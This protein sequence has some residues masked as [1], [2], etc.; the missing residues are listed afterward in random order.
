MSG[1]D[2]TPEEIWAK[3]WQ[4][5]YNFWRPTKGWYSPENGTT[6]L[7]APWPTSCPEPTQGKLSD[8]RISL[9]PPRGV[10]FLDSDDHEGAYE[11]GGVGRGPV[12][13]ARMASE[14]GPLEPT[15]KLSARGPGNP[16]G[17]YP[18]RIPGDLELSDAWFAEFGGAVDVIDFGHR[19]GAWAPGD[20]N[21]A[22]GAT[23]TP[24]VCYG[25]SG[26]PSD[27]PRVEDL[28]ELPKAW[29]EAARGWV[30]KRSVGEPGE[31]RRIT[32]AE[33]DDIVAEAWESYYA[34]RGNTGQKARTKLYTAAWR[35]AQ[36]DQVTGE[37]TDIEALA[38]KHPD[39]DGAPLGPNATKALGDGIANAELQP[40]ERMLSNAEFFGPEG[41]AEFAERAE[42]AA[43]LRAQNGS[44]ASAPITEVA[45]DAAS[46]THSA[47]QDPPAPVPPSRRVVSVKASTIKPKRVRWLWEGRVALG[48]LAIL[49]GREGIGKST[50][51]YERA[52]R[53]TLG[54]LPGEFLGAP[55]P[56]SIIATEDAWAE[57]IVPRLIAAGA[58]LD[59]V[60]KLEARTEY[61]AETGL[62]LPYDQ[63]ALRAEMEANGSVLLI[64]DPLISRLD[65]NLDTHKNADVRQGLEP[66]TRLAGNLDATVL[67]LLHVNKSGSTD[68]LSSLLGSR[69]FSEVARSVLYTMADPQDETGKRKVLGTPK[70]N[71]GPELPLLGYVI[72]GHIVGYDDDGKPITTGKL[73]WV[74]APITTLQSLLAEANMTKKE[75]AQDRAAGWLADYI[76]SHGGKVDSAEA[77]TAGKDEGHAERTLQRALKDLDVIV[78]KEGFPAK[79]YW[80]LPTASP[81]ESHSADSTGSA[82]PSS[83]SRATRAGGPSELARLPLGERESDMC[84]DTHVLPIGEPAPAGPTVTSARDPPASVGLPAP[85]E[86]TATST[87]APPAGTSPAAVWPPD[88]ALRGVRRHP[89]PLSRTKIN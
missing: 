37:S 4:P 24:S 17:K 55:R 21:P 38:R 32:L 81:V 56:V 83:T 75:T 74:N 53:I 71:L 31:P 15:W 48:S 52:A 28:P 20:V 19:C 80:K 89:S 41:A 72:D 62:S 43:E 73:R 30:P 70:N 33:A 88:F 76:R 51:A 12:T 18:Y 39:Y 26:A 6:G 8:A 61:D 64:L 3:G 57:T 9:R 2:E 36:H 13:L 5:V 54:H 82:E 35:Q 14:F 44:V 86:V 50:V 10:A 22:H 58:D 63:E 78:V 60:Y 49:G 42:R 77:K 68:A 34:V 47:E 59:R 27:L 29:I 79:T 85:A 66:L 87:P 1:Y 25:P 65:V 23:A 69:A 11:R 67:G 16:A 7:A 46:A 84:V 40:W 45:Q